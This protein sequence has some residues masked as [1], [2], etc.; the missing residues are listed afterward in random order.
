MIKNWTVERPVN[1]AKL[2]QDCMQVELVTLHMYTCK[3][4]V[5]LLLL[6]GE[7]GRMNVSWYCMG[8]YLYFSMLF[9]Y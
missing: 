1:E 9:S 2:I 6:F 7:E 5:C 3:K 8:T 4:F